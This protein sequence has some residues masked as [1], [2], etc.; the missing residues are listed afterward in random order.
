MV[1]FRSEPLEV[2]ADIVVGSLLKNLGAK[3][4]PWIIA[5]VVPKLTPTCLP[6][7][8][9]VSLLEIDSI[10]SVEFETIYPPFKGYRY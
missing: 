10:I 7:P 2:G 9:D 6:S 4:N 8:G 1:L 3:Y 5:L